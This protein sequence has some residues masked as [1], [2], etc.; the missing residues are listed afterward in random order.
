MIDEPE[1]SGWKPPLIYD[2]SCDERRLA[3]QADVDRL[4][5]IAR[6]Y[7]EVMSGIRR[8][9]SDHEQRIKFMPGPDFR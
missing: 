9:G 5:M 4:V 8:L 3:T 6:L 2:L 7:E 1:L